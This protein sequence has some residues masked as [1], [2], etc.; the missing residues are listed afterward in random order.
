VT[1]GWQLAQVN[2]GRLRAPLGAPQLRPFM[3]ALDP[4]NAIADDSPGFIWRLKTEEGNA[5]AVQA[6]TWDTGDSVGVIINMSVWTDVEHL[7]A[8]VLGDAHRVVLRRRREFF[9]R[10]PEAYLACWW[11]PAGHVPTTDEAEERVRHLRA[12]GPT[13]Y[14][15][16]LR[17]HYRPPDVD[18]PHEPLLNDDGRL[19]RA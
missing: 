14:A 17:H 9:E 8:F 13:P 3:E 15:F 1:V 16:T 10:M 11:V 18:Q 19:C 2:I 5:T 12:Y 4:V 6:F 7:T